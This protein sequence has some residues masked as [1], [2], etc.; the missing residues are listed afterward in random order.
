MGIKLKIAVVS[1]IP[2]VLLFVLGITIT[3]NSYFVYKNSN[4]IGKLVNIS[5]YSSDLI[6]ELQKE[7][8]RSAIFISCQ[9]E[10]CKDDYEKQINETN[11]KIST[12]KKLSNNFVDVQID[13][14]P[15]NSYI[16]S[17]NSTRERILTFKSDVSE[18]VTYY[19]ET[20]RSLVEVI[21]LSA[22]KTES[23]AIYKRLI[24][25][26]ALVLAKEQTGIERALIGNVLSSKELKAD[27]HEKMIGLIRAENIY[28]NNFMD[29]SPEPNRTNFKT[30]ILQ[31]EIYKEVNDIKDMVLKK[32]DF[33][34]EAT[35]W[36][37]KITQHIDNL[38]FFEDSFTK[39]LGDIVKNLVSSS[40]YKFLFI[41]VGL[42]S[43]L[44]I[45]TFI[46]LALGNSIF[47]QIG[48]E[49]DKANQITQ[50]I[51]EGDLTVDVNTNFNN[52]ILGN[53]DFMKDELKTIV[54]DIVKNNNILEK[55]VEEFQNISNKISA[56]IL[57]QSDLSAQI[58]TAAEEMS[59]TI[60]EVA[61]NTSNVSNISSDV[62]VKINS[63]NIMV[64]NAVTSINEA[65]TS[66]LQLAEMINNFIKNSDEI[67]EITNVIEEIA[68]QTNLLAL[69]A[70]IEAARAGEHGR[71]F[72][73]VADE[74]R[75]LAE[76]TIKATTE[77]SGKISNIQTEAN[78]T[79]VSMDKASESVCLSNDNITKLG[80]F[81]KEINGEVENLNNEMG[82]V[83]AAVEEQ[84]AVSQQ[85][86]QNIERI[87][88]LAEH[89]EEEDKSSHEQVMQISEV[90][91][92]LSSAVKKFKL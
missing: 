19:T 63:C 56:K 8:G 77:I 16:N 70:A 71:G 20:I 52:S 42:I 10:K 58:A 86:A 85:I 13:T 14:T 91:G 84:S 12:Y 9:T 90:S 22:K 6:H 41:S 2:L 31:S 45:V 39:E 55:I 46:S 75:K 65:N 28:I 11:K 68:D 5:V 92:E 47:K 89:I 34:I 29:A 53:L 79:K 50:K 62:A 59:S 35:Y 48:G 82:Q 72:A 3:T 87:S 1:S 15:I 67:W 66:A 32:H 38:K 30:N 40:F 81:L 60:S 78:K 76:K 51:A 26:N 69:N 44:I 17:I 36:F 24:S 27:L 73:V 7:R 43:C 37:D 49:P 18:A 25:L 21:A 74:V 83:A 88:S 61:Q 4:Y 80:E 64:R 23:P 57:E 33:S 54:K